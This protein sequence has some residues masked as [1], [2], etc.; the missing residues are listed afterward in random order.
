MT[1]RQQRRRGILTLIACLGLLA[2]PVGQGQQAPPFGEEILKPVRDR[3]APDRRV[4][5]FDVTLERK[6][7]AVV[8][9]GNVG[10]PE[11]KEA[12]LAA[13]RAAGYTLV[14]QVAVLP[15]PA[16]GPRTLGL[17][18]VSVASMRSRASHF[19]D[20][21]TEAITGFPVRVLKR[22]GGWVYVQTLPDNYLGWLQTGHIALVSP[23]EAAA[24]DGA[25]R[26]VVTAHFALVRQRAAVEGAPVCDLAMGAILKRTGSEGAWQAVELPDG[27]KGFVDNSAVEDLA[28]W[29]ASRKP[30]PEAIEKTAAL[31]MGVPYLWGGTSPRGFDCSGFSKTVF[32]LNGIELDRDADQQG[33][34]GETVPLDPGFT[35]VKKGDLLFFGTPATGDKPERITHIA[36]SLGGK[37]FIHATPGMVKRNSFDPASPIYSESLLTRLVKVR[38]ILK[39]GGTA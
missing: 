21:V 13:V 38:R 9:K 10:R 12:V 20:F 27:R 15:D 25:P 30:T 24:W 26:L 22:D 2:S 36:I 35:Q 33:L 3:F 18:T 7:R 8:A 11:A 31:F 14:D 32:R 29:K 6:D 5:V 34:Q 19:A 17:V 39:A 4:A 1:M 23:E 16:L 28:S 37:E